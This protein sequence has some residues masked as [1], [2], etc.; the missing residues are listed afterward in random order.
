MYDRSY[1]FSAG[2]ATMPVPVLEE[3]RDEMLNYRGSGMSVM[4]MSHRSKMFQQIYDEAEAD[5][6]KLMG[7]PNN[8]KVLFIQGGATLQF[9]MIPM[10]LLK[11]GVADYI[12]TGAWSKKAFKE[13]QKFGD[14]KCVASS[15]DRN[16]SYLPD[17][18]DLPIREN[19]DYVYI[20]ENET[21]HGTAFQTLPNTKGK[22][23]VSDQ[24]SM[25]LSKPCNVSD[26]GVIYGGVQ[27]NIGPAGLAIVIIREDLIR[28]D[29][30]PKTPVYMRYDTHADAG[31]MYN[32][33][34]C[35][36]IYVCGKVF[37]YLLN[38][39]GLEAMAKYNEEKAKVLYD[40]LDGSALFRGTVE[41]QFRSLMNVPFVTGSKELD[42][43]VVAYTKAAGFD[44]LKGHKSVGGLRASIYNAMPIEGV[45]ALVECLKQFESQHK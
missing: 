15:E 10:N 8:Y 12:V 20:C 1:N 27:K 13:A 4:E 28:S 9:S 35:W 22:I 17:C 16:F 41:K 44:N 32:T 21:I 31:S 14:V 2:P 34:N 26:Y 43:E 33:P 40:Y 11:N 6:R 18:S 36:A 24:S 37:K 5:L 45:K 42:A 38:M 19:A 30:D 3:I 23:L 39:G 7:I 25:F 29:L